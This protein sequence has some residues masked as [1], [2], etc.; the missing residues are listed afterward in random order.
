MGADRA[1]M[2]HHIANQIR[3]YDG[4]KGG[5]VLERRV[6]IT[7]AEMLALRATPKELVPAPGANKVLEFVGVVIKY[8][9]GSTGYTESNANLVV[10]YEGGQDVCTAIDATN[11]IDQ[12]NDEIR[13]AQFSETALATTVDLEALKNDNLRLLNNGAAEWTGGT[14][15]LDVRIQYRV[16][17]FDY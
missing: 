2:Y 14:G 5:V 7:S 17:D 16:H 3:D 1:N 10:E 15:R 4:Y 8:L 13:M 9:A 11:F 12:T 6:E